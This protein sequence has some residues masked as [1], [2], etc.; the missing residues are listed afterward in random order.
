MSEQTEQSALF[1]WAAL[2][3]ELSLLYAIPNGGSRNMLEAVNLKRAGVKAG[4]PDMCLAMARKGYHGLYIELKRD[5][6][7]KPTPEQT[8]WLKRLTAAGYFA[9]VCHGWDSARRTIEWYLKLEVQ[10]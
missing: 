8:E 5:N 3:P 6:R 4:V 1:Q 9:T 10:A 2:I 7:G